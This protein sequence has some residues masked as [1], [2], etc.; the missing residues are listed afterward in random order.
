MPAPATTTQYHWLLKLRSGS[1]RAQRRKP[2]AEIAQPAT[3]AGRAPRLSRIRPPNWA[4]VAKPAK[5]VQQ[6]EARLARRA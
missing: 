3:T 6:V 4:A 2:T 1:C 5:K